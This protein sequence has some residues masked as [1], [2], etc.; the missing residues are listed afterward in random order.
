MC[1]MKKKTSSKCRLYSERNISCENDINEVF[2][3]KCWSMYV[4]ASAAHRE[5]GG[6]CGLFAPALQKRGVQQGQHGPPGNTQPSMTFPAPVALG[7]PERV[8]WKSRASSLLLEPFPCHPVSH[9]VPLSAHSQVPM[10]KS[11]GA[12]LPAAQ[13]CGL[14]IPGSGKGWASLG[15]PRCL[16]DV[17]HVL[18]WSKGSAAQCELWDEVAA[19]ADKS[20]LK[21]A[22]CMRGFPETLKLLPLRNGWRFPREGFC[23]FSFFISNQMLSKKLIYPCME[24]YFAF[25]IFFPMYFVDWTTLGYDRGSSKAGMWQM[26]LQTQLGERI[27]KETWLR[28]L[29]FYFLL[30]DQSLTAERQRLLQEVAW[31]DHVRLTQ[32]CHVHY[33]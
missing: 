33:T 4:S 10:Q 23:W 7:V 32:Y 15:H 14:P 24:I 5:E 26:V 25:T 30:R 31:C 17:V 13:P 21:Y 27:S 22:C 12:F 16:S 29:L 6:A 11:C 9:L 2:G 3:N 19:M 20:A 8:F 28:S 18:L 1:L